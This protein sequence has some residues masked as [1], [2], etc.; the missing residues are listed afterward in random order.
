MLH[1]DK[2]P[3]F[4]ATGGAWKQTNHSPFHHLDV[5]QPVKPLHSGKEM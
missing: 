3:S 4:H 5:T 2:M 1:F